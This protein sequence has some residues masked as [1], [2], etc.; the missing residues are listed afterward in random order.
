MM[1]IA[2]ILNEHK[3]ASNEVKEPPPQIL[4][5]GVRGGASFT[6]F[7]AYLGFFDRVGEQPFF[8]GK[9]ENRDFSKVVGNLYF[10][11]IQKHLKILFL[12]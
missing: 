11:A 5:A 6:L 10:D 8:D 2:A 1:A 12:I 3:K 9:R 7:D 4:V